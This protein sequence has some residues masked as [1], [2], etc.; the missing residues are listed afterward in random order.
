MSDRQTPDE[1]R[2]GAEALY[3]VARVHSGECTDEDRRALDEWLGQAEANR[4]AYDEV[5]ATWDGMEPFKS[6]VIPEMRAARAYPRRRRIRLLPA[7]AAAA[8]VLAT[9]ASVFWLHVPPEAPQSFARSSVEQRDI[10]LPDG[11]T[12]NLNV[13][14]GLT[15][16]FTEDSRTVRL[17]RGEALFTIAEGDAR[18]FEVLA[19]NGRIRDIGTRFDVRIDEGTTSVAV[20]DG[21]VDVTVDKHG[22]AHRLMAGEAFDYDAAGRISPVRAVDADARTAW[23]EGLLVL[24]GVTLEELAREMARYNRI[25]IRVS[26]PAINAY[27]IS[28]T[29]SIHGIDDMLGAIEAMLPVSVVREQSGILL[30]AR[31]ENRR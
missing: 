13:D 2:A 9:L 17:E 18:A 15:V 8:L 20:L 28:G 23:T 14:S 1:R 5:R 26:D 22:H 21:I 7:A 3:W 30:L 31:P 10:R 16:M 12:V 19:G 29:F 25:D 6:A 11:S 4:R 24:N 27:R